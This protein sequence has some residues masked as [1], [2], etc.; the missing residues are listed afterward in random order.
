MKSSQCVRAL[1]ER[2]AGLCLALVDVGTRCTLCQETVLTE[3]LTVHAFGVVDAVEVGFAEDVDV[4]LFASHLRVRLGVV[5]LRAEAV[6][7]GH[8][9]LADRVS[10]ARLVVSDALVDIWQ[11]KQNSYTPSKM[12][13][14]D[15]AVHTLFMFAA[16]LEI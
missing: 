5:A 4:D 8:G 12:E 9:V 15:P 3:T 11:G 2:S 13:A 16:N 6:V 7:A 1:C 10:S 14:L